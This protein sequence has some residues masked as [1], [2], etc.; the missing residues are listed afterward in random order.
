MGPAGIFLLAGRRR[1]AKA[2]H[3]APSLQAAGATDVMGASPGCSR[4]SVPYL[5]PEGGPGAAEVPATPVWPQG[6]P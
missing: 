5:H 1:L 4:I 2:L 6:R 3:P